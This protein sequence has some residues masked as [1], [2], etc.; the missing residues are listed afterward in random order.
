LEERFEA[1]YGLCTESLTSPCYKEGGYWLGPVWAPVTYIMLDALRENGYEGFARRLAEKF[2]RL[3]PI[4][5]MAENYDPVSG[6][7][8]DDPA[9]SWT[10]CVFLQLLK[11]YPDMEEK[12]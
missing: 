4:G 9:F 8:Y 12:E 5:L 2:V 3:A 1:A 11:E 7:G 10:S 6:K